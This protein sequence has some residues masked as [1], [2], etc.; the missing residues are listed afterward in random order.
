MITATYFRYFSAI[1]PDDMRKD[2]NDQF[3][4]FQNEMEGS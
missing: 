1:M 3:L 4:K 2:F